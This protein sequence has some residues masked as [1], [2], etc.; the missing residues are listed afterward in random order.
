MN[1]SCR[2]GND[3]VKRELADDQIEEACSHVFERDLLVDVRDIRIG[4]VSE[5]SRWPN[6]QPTVPR[7]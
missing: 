5:A 6:K 7:D 4:A 2:L 1:C 3:S